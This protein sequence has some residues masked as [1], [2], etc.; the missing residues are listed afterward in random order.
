MSE[1]F[2]F[3]E[4]PLHS[5]SH[6]STSA[7]SAALDRVREKNEAVKVS[8]DR[9]AHELLVVNAV[10]KEEIPDDAQTGELALALE[11]SDAIEERLQESTVDLAEVNQALEQQIGERAKLE[12]ELAITKA[13]LEEATG[14]P[15][16]T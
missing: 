11:R 16:Q 1:D 7:E 5:E 9:S 15:Q 3:V 14:E 12:R 8:V 13:A 2:I 4:T 10:L 6:V